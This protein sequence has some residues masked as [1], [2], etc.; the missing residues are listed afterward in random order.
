MAL[1]ARKVATAPAGRHSDGKGLMLLVKKSG[2]RSWVFRYQL[3][4]KRR[5]MGLGPYPE[6]NLA[7]AREK[8]MVLRRQLIEGV[9]PLNSASERVFTFR[10]LAAEL[11]ENKRPG[12]KNAKHAA[13]WVSTLEAYAYPILGKMDVRT[14]NTPQVHAALKPIW[15][16]KPETASRVRQR[17]EAVLDYASALGVRDGANPARWR[18]HLQNILPRPSSIRQVQHHPAL[19]W[20][21]MPD[22]MAELSKRNGVSAKALMFTILTAARSGEVRGM[23]WSEVNLKTAVWTVPAD[24]MK[25]SK[26]H[27]VPL[28]PEAAALLGKPGEADQLAFGN[29]LHPS[30]LLSDMALTSVLRKMGRSDITVHGFRST[31]RDWAGE[32]TSFPREVIEAA[33]AHQLRDK[34]EAAYARG[35]LFDKRRLLMEAWTSFL[36]D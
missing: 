25:T 22:F 35:D 34:A 26:E 23:Q 6:I 16:A 33:L 12:W 18:G 31:F 7:A 28:T 36:M 19:D 4:G 24:R 9:D 11:I 10:D 3:D 29:P 1:S 2:A 32:T 17:I 13:Q 5:D 27:R 8:V 21:E 14:I 15:T 20:Q 30:R